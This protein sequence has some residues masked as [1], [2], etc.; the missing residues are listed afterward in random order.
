MACLLARHR[1]LPWAVEERARAAAW[2]RLGDHRAHL[3]DWRPQEDSALSAQHRGPYLAVAARPQAFVP[4]PCVDEASAPLEQHVVKSACSERSSAT[5]SAANQS[6]TRQP[7]ARH[8]RCVAFRTCK[9]CWPVPP[10]HHE[11]KRD[12]VSKR[13]FRNGTEKSA[14]REACV[15][16]T[17]TCALYPALVANRQWC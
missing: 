3:Q 17:H 2:V 11:Q 14:A 7:L 10:G 16:C 4:S 13:L 1:Q 15:T 5:F 12:S 6:L 8:V 9:S